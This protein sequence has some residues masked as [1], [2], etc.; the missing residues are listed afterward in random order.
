[1]NGW[2][3]RAF[4]LLMLAVTGL[5]VALGVWQWMRLKEKEALIARVTERLE[6]DPVPYAPA[7]AE[8]GAYDYRR[9]IVEGRFLATQSV[10]V[11]TSLSDPRGEFSGPGYWVMTP[12]A[13]ERGGAIWVNR[14]FI[15]DS[16]RDGFDPDGNLMAGAVRLSGIAVPSARAS[17]FTPAPN[18]RDRVEWVRDTMRLSALAPD[19]PEPVAPVYLDLPA[20]A[21]G[22]LPQG[23]ETVVEFHNNHLGYAL[24]WFGFAILTPILLVFWLSRQRPRRIP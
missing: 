6:A 2:R 8:Q 1:M 9:I 20:S 22:E 24:T 21:P 17:T 19:L 11:F 14:G 4:V 3:K 16:S 5:F 13:L 7:S 12:L 10:F 18:L 23:G 15:P